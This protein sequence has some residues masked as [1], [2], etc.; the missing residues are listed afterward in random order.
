MKIICVL[1]LLSLKT[2][3]AQSQTLLPV[4]TIC[5]QVDQYKK[6]LSLAVEADCLQTENKALIIDLRLS[7]EK[8][9]RKNRFML[10]GIVAIVLIETVRQMAK[11]E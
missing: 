6:V 8:V 10:G 11:D 2:L 9:K 7:K 3:C 4:D 1:I 5:L